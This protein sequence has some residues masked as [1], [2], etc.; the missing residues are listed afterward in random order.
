MWSVSWG[1]LTHCAPHL[2]SP[3][4]SSICPVYSFF[5]SRAASGGEA[6][7]RSRWF[8]SRSEGLRSLGFIRSQVLLL[9]VLRHGIT[10][11]FTA[12]GC[13]LPSGRRRL[14]FAAF[15]FV[16]AL[17]DASVLGDTLFLPARRSSSR[18]CLE[19]ATDAVCTYVVCRVVNGS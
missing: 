18:G 14:A 17:G 4:S 11:L 6:I 15:R 16:S 13:R 19:L 3:G 2:F 10:P 5:I 8:S 12:R 7:H 1:S 9:R